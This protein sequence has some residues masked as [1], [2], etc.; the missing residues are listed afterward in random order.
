[1]HPFWSENLFWQPTLNVLLIFSFFLH[2][3]SGMYLVIKVMFKVG[4][5][6]ERKW[7]I[8]T[9]IL[10][11]AWI[12]LIHAILFFWEVSDNFL[13]ILLLQRCQKQGFFQFVFGAILI[14]AFYQKLNVS[15]NENLAK[16]LHKKNYCKYFKSIKKFINFSLIQ[17]SNFKKKLSKK[18]PFKNVTWYKRL[19]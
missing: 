15:D 9:W 1:M 16:L 18:G 6:S 11:F 2:F 3:S 19:L 13:Q 17:I 14:L 4:K 8:L 12:Y 10:Q 5:Q 7:N